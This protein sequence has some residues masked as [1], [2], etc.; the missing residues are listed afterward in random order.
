MVQKITVLVASVGDVLR[1]GSTS[2]RAWPAWAVYLRTMGLFCLLWYVVSWLTPNKLLLPSPIDVA[3]AMHERILDGELV[4]NTV[5][6]LTRLLIS[7]LI[8]ALV[9][10]PAG[11]AMGSNRLVEDLLDWPVELLRPIAGIAWIPLALFMFGIG[12][13]LPIFIMVY[14]AFFPMLLG[15]AAGVRDVDRRLI[16]AARTMGIPK[17]TLMRRVIF[18]AALPSIMTSARLAVAASWTAVVAAELVGSPSGLGYAIEYYRSMLDTAS[19]MAFIIVIGV[20]GF[21]CDRALRSLSAALIP[22]ASS[23]KTQ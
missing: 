4:A 15:T 3:S 22:W 12:H 16:A 13:G 7:V 1:S 21:L 8:A 5:V 11:L 23:E 6:S 18:P 10:I 14:T 20:L 2:P 19:V 17:R 9:A